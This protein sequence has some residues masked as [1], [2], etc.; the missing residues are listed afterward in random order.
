M[1]LRRFNG[2]YE[3]DEIK[4][5]VVVTMDERK[6][7]EGRRRRIKRRRRRRRRR[8]YVKIKVMRRRR[9]TYI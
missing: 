5:D 6:L 1:E 3:I 7:L 9:Y 4:V 8:K 2:K